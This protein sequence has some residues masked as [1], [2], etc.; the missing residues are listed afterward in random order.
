MS[1]RAVLAGILLIAAGLRFCFLDRHSLWSDELFAVWLSRFSWRDLF[2]VVRSVDFHP[3]LYY[4]L[5]KA[6]IGLAGTGE[7][8]LRTPSAVCSVAGVWLTYALARRMTAEPVALLG[9]LLLATAPFHI[10]AGQEARMYP[11]L[12]ALTLGATLTLVHAV[13]RAG[14]VRWGLYGLLTA[15]MVCTA[16][17]GVLVIAAHAV[18]IVGWE[19]R[20]L[21]WWLPAVGVAACLCAPWVP[22]LWAQL[23]QS[24]AYDHLVALQ[25]LQPSAYGATRVGDL[26]ALFAFGGSLYGT[27]GYFSVSAMRPLERVV[28]LL[29]F[30][31]L[32]GCGVASVRA[33][34]SRAALLVLLLLVP[35]TAVAGVSLVRPIFLPR[36]FSFLAPFWAMLVALGIVQLAGSVRSHPR[37]FAAACALAVLLYALP[38]L[39]RY[40]L[41]PATWA[42]R[43]R[44]A[45]AAARQSASPN[46]L[47]LYIDT[48]AEQTFEYYFRAP[49][50][51]LTLGPPGS[52]GAASLTRTQFLGLTRY[53][54]VW[55]VINGAVTPSVRQ[56]LVPTL[57][58]TFRLGAS[59]D[60]VGASLFRFDARPAS[61]P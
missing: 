56:A 17:L 33:G 57:N 31:V 36:W 46:D 42:Y 2:L 5:M 59:Y 1:P 32:I 3:P 11:L 48:P 22:S 37:R 25:Q 16:Y 52:A 9:A 4:A 23:G 28:V 20:R 7:A 34:R 24:R 27:A 40:Y 10:M 45:A 15:L 54:H 8:A 30:L 44:E 19:R 55:L 39:H 51:F 26:L 61:P 18:W 6:W 21:G 50:A 13:E 29:P 60:F 38:V 53:R 35:I 58:T 14:V 12:G 49:H 43:W 47:F 41:E